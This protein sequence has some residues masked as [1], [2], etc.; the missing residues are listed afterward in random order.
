MMF[1]YSKW[2]DLPFETRIK[3]ADM[4]GIEK[5]G[6]TEVFEN[7]VVNDGYVV[8]ELEEAITV[9]NVQKLFS[10]VQNDPELLWN[11]LVN[12]AEGKDAPAVGSSE[13]ISDKP[14]GRTKKN[15]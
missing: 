3:I 2:L 12:K 15:A 8:K 13:A 5:K 9:E 4:L 1:K 6:A 11:K 14:K 7:R 10:E